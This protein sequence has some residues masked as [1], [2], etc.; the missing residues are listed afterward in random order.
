MNP[1]LILERVGVSDRDFETG[2]ND[3]FDKY[4][5]YFKYLNQNENAKTSLTFSFGRVSFTS[6][7]QIVRGDFDEIILGD[8]DGNF[9]GSGW[10]LS[11]KQDN[12]LFTLESASG[13]PVLSLE[14]TRPLLVEALQSK[15]KTLQ[16]SE[17]EK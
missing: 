6:L 8:S 2:F 4:E 13:G 3:G 17:S 15:I 14:F 9:D 16:I 5:L 1:I 7:K 11:I 12:C 10:T